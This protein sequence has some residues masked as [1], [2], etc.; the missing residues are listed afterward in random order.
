[1]NL[2]QQLMLAH[3]QPKQVIVKS[4]NWIKATQRAGETTTNN[5]IERY[6]KVM[7]GKGWMQQSQI[8]SALGYATTVSTKFLKKLHEELKLI[9]KRNR[10]GAIKYA[11]KHGYEY[12]W[13]DGT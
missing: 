7:A 13:K 3:A 9:E 6:R 2:L 1:M 8:E 10:A 5:A 4:T 12:R 11:R